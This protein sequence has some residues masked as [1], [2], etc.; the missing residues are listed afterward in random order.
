MDS[1]K[2]ATKRHCFV[3]EDDGLASIVDM[4]VG[5]SGSHH[6]PLVSRPLYYTTTTTTTTTSSSSYHIQRKSSFRNVSSGYVSSPRSGN[7]RFYDTARY[8]EDPHQPHFL[9]SCFGCKKPLGANRD[10]FM[11]RGD[12]P[13]CSED[14]RQEQIEIDESKEKSWNLSASMRALRKKEQRKS[15][16]S[17]K[18]SQDCPPIRTST[19]AAA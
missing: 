6:Y 14:C 17:N 12:T 10:I 19:V 18:N 2:A 1:T 11:Y 3:E 15:A 8:F 9:D 5:F 4:E 7:I 16:S 13:F